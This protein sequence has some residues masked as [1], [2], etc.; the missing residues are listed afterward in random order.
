MKK[1]DGFTSSFIFRIEGSKDFASTEIG[2]HEEEADCSA[3]DD[4]TRC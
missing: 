3:Y 2:I 4:S 1:K